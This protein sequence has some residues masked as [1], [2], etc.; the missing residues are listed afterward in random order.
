MFG[1]LQVAALAFSPDQ[2]H[3][4]DTRQRGAEEN[5]LSDG[6]Q[7]WDAHGP[8]ARTLGPPAADGELFP[9]TRI[10]AAVEKRCHLI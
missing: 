3:F 2:N 6:P 7:A 10:L 1:G 8:R 9:V 5:V 4:L